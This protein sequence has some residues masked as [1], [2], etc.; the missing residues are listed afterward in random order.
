MLII[1]RNNRMAM[2]LASM[3]LAG[4]LGTVANTFIIPRLTQA[5]GVASATWLVSIFSAL[6]CGA[7]VAAIMSM[8]TKT[9]EKKQ[10]GQIDVL[11]ALRWM[12]PEFT[13]LCILGFTGYGL[14]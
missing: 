13:Y 7:T 2:A 9:L 11:G 14:M 4:T 3:T 5:R 8:E 10:S 6:V 12:P 1:S